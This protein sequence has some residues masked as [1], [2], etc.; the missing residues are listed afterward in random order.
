V[1]GWVDELKGGWTDRM[2]WR[3][4]RSDKNI[5][6]RKW[7]TLCNRKERGSAKKCQ[8]NIRTQTGSEEE[9]ALSNQDVR[10]Q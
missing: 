8:L 5:R 7:W 10:C 4:R 1:S 3:V 9:A 6:M 2:S